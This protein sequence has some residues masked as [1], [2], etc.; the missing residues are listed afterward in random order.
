MLNNTFLISN[1][2]LHVLLQHIEAN[3]AEVID[4]R[5]VDF[6]EEPDVRGHH[7]VD[8][9]QKE[10]QPVPATFVRGALGPGHGDV[11]VPTIIRVP[12]RI[13]AGQRLLRQVLC[14]RLDPLG[15][16]AILAASTSSGF[17]AT[18]SSCEGAQSVLKP[19]WLK[20]KS[21]RIDL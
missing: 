3:T 19:R 9:G 11:E 1:T 5:M 15:I 16:A 18:A 13:H 7:R 10:L 12:L 8:L 20:P 17:G 2:G 6:G 14:L 4:L 21:R